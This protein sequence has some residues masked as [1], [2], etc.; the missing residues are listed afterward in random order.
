M[1]PKLRMNM[2]SAINIAQLNKYA[3]EYVRWSD[4]IQEEN[5]DV[6]EEFWT[7]F[8]VS[9]FG[10]A[11]SYSDYHDFFEI[12]SCLCIRKYLPIYWCKVITV[13]QIENSWVKILWKN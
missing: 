2:N 4:I 12:K 10:G 5:K 7:K 8:P 1:L 13:V 3:D 6:L 9:G 11:I